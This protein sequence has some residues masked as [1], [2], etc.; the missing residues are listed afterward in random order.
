MS[1]AARYEGAPGPAPDLPA[2][3]AALK[4][5]IGAVLDVIEGD[6]RNERAVN[7]VTLLGIRLAQNTAALQA[8]A[9]SR[10]EAEVIYAAGMTKG[11]ARAAARQEA[12]GRHRAGKRRPIPGQLA[13]VK[14]KGAA[15]PAIA[16]AAV[17]L[18]R[19]AKVSPHAPV[20]GAGIKLTTLKAAALATAIP[21]AGAL[22]I[23]GAVVFSHPSGAHGSVPGQGA[24]PAASVYAGTPIPS[25]SLIA[26]NV[27]RPKPKHG[28]KKQLMSASGLPL[29]C[30]VAGPEP[31]ASA[32][33]SASSSPSPA[34]SVQAGPATLGI[35][36]TSLD[37]SLIPQAT[38]TISATGSGWAS[39][40]ISTTGND[41]DFS[42]SSG[43]LQAGG[44]A[45]VTVSLAA[46]L[47]ALTAQVFEVDGQQVTVTLPLPV[48]AP[49]V[50]PTSVIPSG[51]LPSL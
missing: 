28:S 31:S 6:P 16:A 24:A 26:R 39:W 22:A 19:V 20:H 15:L 18:R 43:V 13:L 45:T 17:A 44:S 49:S 25:T 36:A 32:S 9:A 37:L 41:L 35:S 7:E 27:T 50:S 3:A 10:A 33:A 1:T 5:R 14:M 21:A 30:C 47:D 38:F 12:P 29:P 34:V 4:A 8:E 2:E 23:T 51:V 40:R 42:P 11:E 46:S 48:P